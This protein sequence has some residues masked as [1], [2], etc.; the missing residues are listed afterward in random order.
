MDNE[1][2]KDID[3]NK[4]E[5]IKEE[6]ENVEKKEEKTD[7][8]KPERTKLKSFLVF[9]SLIAGMGLMFMFQVATGE[10]GPLEEITNVKIITIFE[11]Y[12]VYA[13]FVFGILSA[14]FFIVLNL[15]S[16]LF[17]K[18]IPWPRLLISFIVILPWYFVAHQLVY[19]EP[20]NVDYARAIISY[21]A[22]PLLATFWYLLAVLI[23]ILLILVVIKI[24]KKFRNPKY[25]ALF[26][27]PFLLTGCLGETAEIICEI[28]PESDHCFQAAAG[29]ENDPATCEKIKGTKFASGNSNPPKDKCFLQIAEN[30]G[31][32]TICDKI[33]GGPLSYTKEECYLGTSIKHSN[34]T[35]CKMLSGSDYDACKSEVSKKIDPGSVLDID[36]QIDLLKNELKNSP[37]PELE[38]QLSGLE[39][40]KKDYLDIMNEGNRKNY[41]TLADPLNKDA[42]LSFHLGEIDE[43]TKN[44]LVALNDSLREK[45]E[46]MS[47]KEYKAIR[48]MLAYKNDPKNDI[49]NM[50]DR[51]I[52]KL[53]WDEKLGAG[54]DY[55]KFWNS[56]KT[57]SEKN[58]DEQLLFYSRML[59]KEEA[60]QKGLNDRQQDFDRNYEKVKGVIKDEI[61][62]KVVD[63]AKKAAFGELVDIVSSSAEAPVT[64]VLGEAIDTVKKEAK[65]AEFR[66]LV[67]AYD[68]GMKEELEKA[69]GNVE[70]AHAA[71]VENM[72]K[73]PYTYEDKNTFAKYG[74]ILE[75]KDCDGTNPHC[76]K[77]DVFWKAMKKSYK[78]QNKIN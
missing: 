26:F 75:N 55:M 61:Y 18:I 8:V 21:I 12:Y 5:I 51:E 44:S 45:G 60:V 31:D 65:S 2:K 52:V 34:P 19:D 76:V 70:K 49:E 58:Y 67:R 64:A 43:K 35:G 30:T 78:Y 13:G 54:V 40:K 23:F 74:N 4:E 11:K 48:D 6:V 41:E 53:R 39:Q 20:R 14:L 57:E 38:K 29:Q 50:S 15:F 66:G 71:V 36:S 10:T 22:Y 1:D 32:L 3:I 62:N 42:M 56:N 47:E 27:V 25:L 68:L 59:E 33:E 73:D 28:M 17:K 72:Q 16:G 46:S 9:L 77:K 7:V 69:G 24:V 37:D 63:E